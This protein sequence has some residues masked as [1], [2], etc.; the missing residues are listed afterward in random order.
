[1]LFFSFDFSSRRNF[2]KNFRTIGSIDQTNRSFDLSQSIIQNL[3]C[4]PPPPRR[5]ERLSREE[6][7]DLVVPK[8]DLLCLNQSKTPESKETRL[9]DPS[10]SAL[11]RLFKNV[12]E[13]S[14]YCRPT[15][16]LGENDDESVT[17]INPTPRIKALSNAQRIRK[18]IFELIETERSY[19]Q[20]M[21]RLLERYIEPLRDDSKLLPADVIESLYVSVKSIHQLQQT[22]LERLESNVPTEILAYNATSEFRHILVAIAETFLSYSQY[23]KLYSTFCAMHLRINR[24]LD[25]HQNNQH[26]KDFLAARNPRHQHSSSFES[27][28]IKPVQRI[29]KYPLLLQQIANFVNSPLETSVDSIEILKL[30]QSI[31]MMNEIGEYMNAMQQLYEDFGQSFEQ[32]IKN[33]SEQRNQVEHILIYHR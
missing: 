4:P 17:P 25:L 18:V 26:L 15:T 14:R 7:R 29:L 12:D 3:I 33:Y 24:L 21:Q 27:Y 32:I 10:G 30:K 20:D 8:P 28:L 22:F 23:F 16:N 11:E 5:I 1:M 19:V 2:K 9:P 6:I 31:T 13:L